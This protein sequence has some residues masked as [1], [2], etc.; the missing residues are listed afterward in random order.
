[1]PPNER[2]QA[3]KYANLASR[4][5]AQF[6]LRFQFNYTMK[7]R[8]FLSLPVLAVI[9]LMAILYYLTIFV[10]I[11]E[12]IG[13]QSSPGTLNASILTVFASLCLFSFV[14]CVLTDPGH[15][16][17]SY[18]P[19]VEGKDVSF[20]QGKWIGFLLLHYL[21]LIYVESERLVKLKW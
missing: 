19:D 15:V 20:T 6:I 2:S 12:W 11:E 16:P 14:V 9:S 8:R 13:L 10:F 3:T 5:E 18:L 7:V 17:S 4:K 1:M 21:C